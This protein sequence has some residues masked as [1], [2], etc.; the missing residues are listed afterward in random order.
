[1]IIKKNDWKKEDVLRM[2]IYYL[3]TTAR[4]T[5]ENMKNKGGK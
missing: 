5:F 1:V 4:K 3:N 2:P